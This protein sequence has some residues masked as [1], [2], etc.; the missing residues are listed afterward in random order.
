MAWKNSNT[1]MYQETR[2]ITHK[3]EEYTD[4]QLQQEGWIEVPRKEWLGGNPTEQ[5]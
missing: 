5:A 4:D 2:P 3:G 1:G